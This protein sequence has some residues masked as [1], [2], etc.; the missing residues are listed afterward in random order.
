M[1]PDTHRPIYLRGVVMVCAACQERREAMKRWVGW[2]A[3]A[4][5]P[6]ASGPGPAPPPVA[7]VP[8]PGFPPR[9]RGVPE[10]VGSPLVRPPDPRHYPSSP[11]R[12]SHG[13][14]VSRARRWP[15]GLG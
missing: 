10:P 6:R 11:T 4:M 1:S 14:P 7:T 8:R 2:A 9:N 13:A 12:N 15:F 3:Q 5:A